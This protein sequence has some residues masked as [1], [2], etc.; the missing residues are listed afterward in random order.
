MAESIAF[1]LS[2]SSQRWKEKNCNENN[3]KEFS[4]LKAFLHE[5]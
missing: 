1:C 2:P 3:K 4:D 5:A